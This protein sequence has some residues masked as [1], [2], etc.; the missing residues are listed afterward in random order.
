[1]ENRNGHINFS[2]VIPAYNAA[3]TIAASIRSVIEQTLQP[4]EIIVVDD[5]STDA[6]AE[7][8]KGFGEQVNY[9]QLI[10]NNGP[11]IARNKGMDMATGDYIAFLDHDDL[12]HRDKL[13]L[14]NSILEAQPQ[15]DFLYHP[16]T[17][18][19][20]TTIQLPESGVVYRMPF[21][22]LLARNVIGTPCVIMK[23]SISQRF[24]PS[25]KYAED[26]DLWLRIGYKHRLHF[27]N[28]PLTQIN[29]PVLSAGGLSSN[30]WKMR[31]G[32]MRAYRRLV[33]LNP[34]FMLLLPFLLFGS[35][36]KHVGKM[37]SKN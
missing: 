19:N 36:I 9:V 6:T 13:A 14:A 26:Y 15:I 5:C 12:W 20:I 16:F 29:R 32:E 11:S 33:K 3:A 27:I 31:K 30:K 34:L 17:L 22:K 23:R 24:E 18:E 1:M 2:V 10:K 35:L 21:M 7:I 28:I 37:L 25:M 8:I 4:Y